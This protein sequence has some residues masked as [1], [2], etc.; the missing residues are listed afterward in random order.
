MSALTPPETLLPFWREL[1]W[2]I[3]Q[4]YGIWGDADRIAGRWRLSLKAHRDLSAWLACA[5]MLLRRLLY[6][7]AA[8]IDP[9][10]IAPKRAASPRPRPEGKA[11]AAPAWSIDRDR[12]ETW[13]VSFR[14][15]PQ[16]RAGLRHAQPGASLSVSKGSAANQSE[17]PRGFRHALPL[18]QRYEALL[19]AFND[20]DRLIL[21]IARTLR[22]DPARAE[23]LAAGADFSNATGSRELF[24]ALA[25]SLDGALAALRAPNTS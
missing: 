7:H 10:G 25:P 4:I 11:A 3:D 6:I 21:R 2:L 22:R 18:A 16:V 9:A 20:P 15:F 13:R 14:L 5:E 19:R 24:E 12:P 23:T 1:R 8:A 17:R